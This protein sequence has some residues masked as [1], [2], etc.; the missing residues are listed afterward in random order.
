[1]GYF[2]ALM[3]LKSSEGSTQSCLKCTLLKASKARGRTEITLAG[4][5]MHPVLRSLRRLIE[6]QHSASSPDLEQSNER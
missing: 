3:P 2:F 5:E 4:V 6:M 1:M